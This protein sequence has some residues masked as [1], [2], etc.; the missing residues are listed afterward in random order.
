MLFLDC[1]MVFWA[2]TGFS[3][4]DQHILSPF[5]PKY[6]NW[7]CQIDEDLHTLFWASKL[8]KLVNLTK[9]VVIIWVKWWQ[10]M[11]IWQRT[12]FNSVSRMSQ[13][14][15]DFI[16]HKLREIIKVGWQWH[17][18]VIFSTKECN[19]F[20]HFWPIKNIYTNY[21]NGPFH[22]TVICQVLNCVGSNNRVCRFYSF[23]RWKI[24]LWRT[25]FYLCTV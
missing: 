25:F 21:L 3:L 10:N 14:A 2:L 23:I 11:L 16:G 15:V 7:I 17:F 13:Q 20:A 19:L 6:D 22:S 18:L 9:S 4:S 1:L 12:T 24:S 5:N 8:A